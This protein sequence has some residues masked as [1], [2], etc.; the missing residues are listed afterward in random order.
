MG[1]RGKFLFGALVGAGLGI[2]F[3]PKSG[4]ETRKELKKKFNELIDKAREIDIEEVEAT[5]ENRISELK[6]E[7]NDLDKEKVLAIARKKASQIK[8]KSEELVNYA[9]DKGTP[10]LRDAAE[11]VKRR[12]IKVAKETIEKL[13]KEEKEEKKDNKKA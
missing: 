5:V 7:L 1:K 13:E 11:E 2:I 4:S 6:E 10:V 8:D 3:A 9:I 12:A